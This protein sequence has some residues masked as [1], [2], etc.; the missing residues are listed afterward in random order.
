MNGDVHGPWHQVGGG[1]KSHLQTYAYT[2]L[3]CLA[4]G[5]VNWLIDAEV[6]LLTSIAVSF[7]IGFSINT[8][9]VTLGGFFNQFLSPYVSPIP[10]TAIGLAIGLYLAG[11]L[12]VGEPL[13]FFTQSFATLVFGVF[14][15]IVG[16][17]LFTT[18]ARLLATQAQ[19]ARAE[20][21][22]ARQ[23][24]LTLETELKLLQAQIEPHFLFNTLSN[25]AGLIHTQ[26]HQAEE[27]LLNFTKLLRAS[28]TRTRM[29]E[30]S[31]AEELEIAKAYLEIH[32]IRMRDR[33]EYEICADEQA[34]QTPIPP[35][36][37]QPLIE[38]AIKHGIDP[39]E[40]GGLISISA[41]LEQD[42]VQISVRD[43][44]MGITPNNANGTGTGLSNVRHRLEALYGA[45]GKLRLREHSEGGLEAIL[46]I[47]RTPESDLN[48][49]ADLS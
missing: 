26:P 9:F 36:L 49:A 5:T 24:R 38:N 15:G 21:E 7:C 44:G 35:L 8:T 39:K 27:T 19:L 42:S 1:F 48:V 31:L 23:E 4:I 3:F 17:L 10:L 45:R 29:A 22:R 33:L 2:G 28:L 41:T 47:P 46:T 43:N 37:V 12:V 20:A 40:E 6:P 34:K 32:R 13:Y 14:F 16:F 25:I 11:A 30:T 18:R